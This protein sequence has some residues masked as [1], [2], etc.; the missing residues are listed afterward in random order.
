[1]APDGA[2]SSADMVTCQTADATGTSCTVT[3]KPGFAYG[4]GV[5]G[6]DAAGNYGYGIFGDAPTAVVPASSAP[7]TLPKAS[8]PLTSSDR[9]SK[10]TVGAQ[11]TLS[12]SGYQPGSVVELVVY[13]TPVSLGSVV[14]DANGAFS[15]TVT[16][17]AS[18]ANGKHH[19]VSVGV[20]AAGNPR[21][22]VSEIIVS[23]GTGL[24]YT[25]FSPAPYLGGGAALL[26]AGAGLIV[27]GRRRRA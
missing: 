15:A 6:I 2:Q 7:A 10:V 18:M 12:G 1:V 27:A 26:L 17:P 21:Y 25:G 3:V 4:Y 22:L 16:L 23:G 20:D 24:A 14:A 9:D 13:S 8:G 5:N 11:V 19:L